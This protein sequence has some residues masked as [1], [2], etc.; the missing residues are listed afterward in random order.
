MTRQ[1]IMSE[2]KWRHYFS[3]LSAQLKSI[4]KERWSPYR[5]SRQ[6]GVYISAISQ[7]M[8]HVSLHYIRCGEMKNWNRTIWITSWKVLL[9]FFI[10]FYV[11]ENISIYYWTLWREIFKPAISI[12]CLIHRDWLNKE[13]SI[14]LVKTQQLFICIAREFYINAF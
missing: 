10:S 7:Q 13:N 14:N 8:N 2:Q 9:N 6:K 4:K 5:Q 3:G 11:V 1:S 12:F